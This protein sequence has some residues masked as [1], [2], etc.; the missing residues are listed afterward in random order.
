MRRTRPTPPARRAPTT[1]AGVA[2][3]LRAQYADLELLEQIT[4]RCSFPEK[5]IPLVIH[6]AL[7][8]QAAAALW[9]RPAGAR[10]A[11]CRRPLQRA[12]HH[13]RARQAGRDLCD[14]RQIR[15]W[16]TSMWWATICDILGP[17]PAAQFG[18]LSRPDRLRRRPAGARSPLRHRRRQ[19]R[20]RTGLDHRGATSAA[21]IEQ[22]GAVV[23]RPWRL[24]ARRHPRAPIAT[25]SPSITREAAGVRQGRAGRAR[26]RR[27]SCRAWAKGGLW[28]R[29]APISKIPKRWRRSSRPSGPTA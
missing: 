29:P 16:P 11:L 13:P 6:N 20:A 24:G 12:A 22:N 21:G 5:L 26:R 17:A 9:R 3:D 19:D 27:R 1:G 15:S 18:D 2:R 14:R 28:P 25:G 23:S 4:G 10:L 7:G 8:R